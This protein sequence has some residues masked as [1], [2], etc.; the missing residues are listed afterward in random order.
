MGTYGQLTSHFGA[1][2]QDI[3]SVHPP[4]KNEY[5][6]TYAEI[7]PVSS[8]LGGDFDSGFKNNKF[9]LQKPPI[10]NNLTRPQVFR[11]GDLS[12]PILSVL[13]Y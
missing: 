1:L 2:N 13:D 5:R 12:A 4:G 10:C 3:I 7:K 6:N 9:L 8:H 11:P